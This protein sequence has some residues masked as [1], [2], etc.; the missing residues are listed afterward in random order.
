MGYLLSRLPPFIP[1]PPRP[2]SPRSRQEAS[3]DPRLQIQATATW[4]T[5][6]DKGESAA[7]V[8]YVLHQQAVRHV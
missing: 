2:C 1:S 7:N 4:T 5:D 3:P 6:T 8:E